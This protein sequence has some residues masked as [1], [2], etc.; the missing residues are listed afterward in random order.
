MQ[1]AAACKVRV[2]KEPLDEQDLLDSQPEI[3]EVED[4]GK[5]KEMKITKK[6]PV[7]KNVKVSIETLKPVMPLIMSHPQTARRGRGFHPG[8]TQI[9]W[10]GKTSDNDS[11]NKAASSYNEA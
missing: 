7:T 3:I 10:V 8:K 11:E 1:R 4:D 5:D 6:S 2:K 9:G